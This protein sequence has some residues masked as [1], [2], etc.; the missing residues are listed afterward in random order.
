MARRGIQSGLERAEEPRLAWVSGGDSCNKP[1]GALNAQHAS[2]RRSLKLGCC[3]ALLCVCVCS[4]PRAVQYKDSVCET[5]LLPTAD[6]CNVCRTLLYETFDVDPIAASR[7]Y[8]DDFA[9][10][11]LPSVWSATTNAG[12]TVMQQTKAPLTC[13][14]GGANPTPCTTTTLV[15]SLGF[16]W[17]NYRARLQFS[18]ITS[19][20][21]VG[22]AFNYQNRQNYYEVTVEVGSGGRHTLRRK[23]DGVY[24]NL[25]ST[26]AFTV[27]LNTPLNIE[28]EARFGRI[29][30]WF[31]G[32]AWGAPVYDSTF[33]SGTVALT[34]GSGSASMAVFNG[35]TVQQLS[36]W[37]PA[38][39]KL[40]MF[41]NALNQH[42]L[43]I[44]GALQSWTAGNTYF[45]GSG[46]SGEYF[47]PYASNT[48]IA[49]R[50][51]GTSG[52]PAIM[53]RVPYMGLET[54][55]A[56][57][58][59]CAPGFDETW[60]QPGYNTSGPTSLFAPATMVSRGQINQGTYYS[61]RDQQPMS[62]W[63]AN[64]NLDQL[65]T[66]LLPVLN[67]LSS[68]PTM[69]SSLLPQLSL[70]PGAPYPLDYN[71][72][73]SI[74][75]PN[76]VGPPGY[77]TPN[78]QSNTLSNPG[79]GG[80]ALPAGW[81]LDAYN[82]GNTRLV[83]SDLSQQ[84]AN[85][86]Y[87][88]GWNFRS[89][90][91]ST[92]MAL[93]HN[94]LIGVLFSFVDTENYLEYVISFLEGYHAVRQHI[95]GISNNLFIS[96]WTGP[97][98]SQYNTV[99]VRMEEGRAE[100]SVN[101]A[102]VWTDVVHPALVHRGTFGLQAMDASCAYFQSTTINLW[103]P[104]AGR[105]PELNAGAWS[106]EGRP[107]VASLGA[108]NET[109]GA[110]LAFYSF[111]NWDR[112][113]LQPLLPPTDQTSDWMARVSVAEDS[114]PGTTGWLGMAFYFKSP[115]DY[116]EIVMP[117]TLDAVQLNR[118]GA[119]G[120]LLS[121]L[122]SAA[123]PVSVPSTRWRELQVQSA[124]GF[125]NV[126]V[127]SAFVCSAADPMAATNTLRTMGSIALLSD[128]T[129][130]GAT[131]MFRGVQFQWIPLVSQDVGVCGTATCTCANGG[132]CTKGLFSQWGAFSCACT[133]AWTGAQ[134]NTA[135]LTPSTSSV[136]GDGLTGGAIGSTLFLNI[137]ARNGS[138]LAPVDGYTASHISVTV[139]FT[140]VFG[141]EV[142]L[143]KPAVSWA[144]PGSASLFLANYTVDFSGNVSV[145]VEF[146]G[147]PIGPGVWSY[148]VPTGPPSAANW[149]VS[150]NGVVAPT[151]NAT[152]YI[153]L[154]SQDAQNNEVQG[155]AAIAAT[156][157]ATV[158]EQTHASIAEAR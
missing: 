127:D 130:P 124:K 157:S 1:R 50:A 88:F 43:Y 10:T 141:F 103:K 48:L 77:W 143:V 34:L 105:A 70:T 30:V 146:D 108:V 58:W 75:V 116:F 133:P 74:D 104:L 117:H 46:T 97:G 132:T 38:P 63:T 114:V 27:P 112:A 54:H 78:L 131:S 71:S 64:G 17:A 52:N 9:A 111:P 11:G 100:V 92:R 3:S 2:E 69:Y 101:E 7:W 26:W 76:Y 15:H 102:V 44:N 4:D 80:L 42:A 94:R 106:F 152:N 53:L 156:L 128:Q 113:W 142:G 109:S 16:D 123:V 119:N 35:V 31:D 62:I 22:F 32:V 93:C 115:H 5:Q 19:A 139:L 107:Y 60:V 73:Q 144:G 82:V 79:G 18:M 89:Y 51:I 121:T 98:I 68:E 136:V 154:I 150:G 134:C 125:L 86:L 12:N 147:V 72:W 118:R 36:A 20:G 140:N 91:F 129:T 137:T 56:L 81:K 155:S 95:N 66:C 110:G 29:L 47:V 85:W 40:R 24:T 135:V 120:T 87:R 96:S 39:Y 45:A 6:S 37:S 145:T 14:N 99:T 148:L 59:L 90:T 65:V 83:A 84:G 67:S 57:G 21:I 28:V 25:L 138:S 8:V 151:L 49:I 13:S 153:Q 61:N 158:R 149:K 126:Y 23:V 122:C 55:A 41:V 33:T